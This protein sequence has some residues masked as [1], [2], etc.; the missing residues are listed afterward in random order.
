MS[1]IYLDPVAMDATAGA[2]GEHAREVDAAVADLETTCSAEV[3]PALA[4]WL[5]AELRDIAVHAR[6]AELV[7]VVAAL[8]TALRAQ[9]IQADQSL[10]TAIPAVGAPAPALSADGFVL[11]VPGTTSYAPPAAPATGFV[12]D[13]D[14][15]FDPS[16]N[17]YVLNNG[18]RYYPVTPG[19]YSGG[20]APSGNSRI[21]E[22]Q[23]MT[24]RLM[25]IERDSWSALNRS[26]SRY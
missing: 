23:T 21:V 18:P 20:V 4:G 10:A 17:G 15:V 1:T 16:G 24:L 7:Y 11:G 26:M 3:P 22:E 5:A 6:L 14:P 9:Q 13:V 2:I 19:T 8:E 25:N 12:L